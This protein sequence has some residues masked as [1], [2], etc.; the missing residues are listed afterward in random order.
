MTST[1]HHEPGRRPHQRPHHR[2]PAPARIDQGRCRAPS[3]TA[4][5]GRIRSARPS[6]LWP[7]ADAEAL[8]GTALLAGWLGRAILTLVRT[9]TRPGDRVLLLTPPASPHLSPRAPGRTDD[10][11]PYTGLAEAVWTVA[12]LGR[13]V[14]TATAA[15]APDYPSGHT[16]PFRHAGAGSGSRPR[17]SR[18]GPCPMA[19]PDTDSAHLRHRVGDRPRG[20]FDLI[21]TAL[22]PH[23]TDWLG[24]TDW[25]AL[26]TPRGLTAVVTHSDLL[27]G[28]LLDPCP[29]LVDTLGSHGLRCLDHIAVLTAPTPDPLASPAATKRT[30][31]ATAPCSRSPRTDGPGALPLRRVHHDLVLFRRP[32]LAAPEGD[33]ADRTETS[34]V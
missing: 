17:P 25:S 27:G 12:R 6:T 24:H 3:R 23:A 34:D 32:P 2:M 14:D 4:I 5:A 19:D 1:P 9:Y 13:G 21:I 33:V 30:V 26:L 20:G 8:P 22:D 28:R 29:V 10:G 7:F 11:D 31:A 16:D 18:P 15:P